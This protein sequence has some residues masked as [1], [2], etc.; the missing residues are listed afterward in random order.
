MNR[1]ATLVEWGC[2]AVCAAL[3]WFLEPLFPRML[4]AGEILLYGSALLLFQGLLRDLY[5]MYMVPKPV[6][7]QIKSH[8]RCLCMESAIGSIGVV[9]GVAMLVAMGM[10]RRVHLPA[11]AWPLLVLLIGTVG[12]SLREFVIDWKARQLQRGMDHRVERA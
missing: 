5:L 1:V 9:A 3:V 10:N 2:I 4:P 8:S 11:Y 12:F 6:T 7:C